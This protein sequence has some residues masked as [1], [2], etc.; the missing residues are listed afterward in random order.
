MTKNEQ[1]PTGQ[2]TSDDEEVVAALQKHAMEVSDLADRGMAA[3]H[4]QMMAQH[5]GN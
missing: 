5:H 3:V 4:E 2:K 1:D